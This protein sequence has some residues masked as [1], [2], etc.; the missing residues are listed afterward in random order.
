MDLSIH[1]PL[2]HVSILRLFYTVHLV[3]NVVFSSVSPRVYIFGSTAD[4]S[5]KTTTQNVSLTD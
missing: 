3:L 2:L 5:A 4:S 1:A